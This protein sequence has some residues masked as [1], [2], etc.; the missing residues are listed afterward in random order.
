MKPSIIVNGLI[1]VPVLRAIRATSP[2]PPVDPN[3]FCGGLA[4][5]IDDAL[6]AVANRRSGLMAKSD[7]H[8][9]QE[10]ASLSP[11]YSGPVDSSLDDPHAS[12]GTLTSKPAIVIA[13]DGETITTKPFHFAFA[14]LGLHFAFFLPATGKDRCK[15]TETLSKL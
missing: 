4:Q 3:A 12:T 13:T 15:D 11:T 7:P 10:V 6:T 14:D 5:P 8:P 2:K 9:G 1:F